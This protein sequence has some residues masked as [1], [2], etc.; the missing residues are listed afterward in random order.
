MKPSYLTSWILLKYFQGSLSNKKRK[1]KHFYC[2]IIFALDI[3]TIW[4]MDHFSWA[5]NHHNLCYFETAITQLLLRLNIW[6]LKSCFIFR[7]WFHE[8]ICSFKK[9]YIKRLGWSVHIIKITTMIL[10]PIVRKRQHS[11]R[12][13]FITVKFIIWL[14]VANYYWNQLQLRCCKAPRSTSEYVSQHEKIC[15]HRYELAAT[16]SERCQLKAN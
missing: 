15:C 10:C 1:S 13:M 7:G 3:M 2:F 6:K 12:L 4:S 5:S 11:E 8:I 9:F 16:S 14:L